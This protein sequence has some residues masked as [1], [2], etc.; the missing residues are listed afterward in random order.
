M[1][2]NPGFLVFLPDLALHFVISSS[3]TCFK[4]HF[5]MLGEGEGVGDSDVT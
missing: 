2:C 4:E 3:L 5:S 1:L